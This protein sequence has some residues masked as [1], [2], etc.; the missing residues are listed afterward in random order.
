MTNNNNKSFDADAR[1]V[2]FLGDKLVDLT[3]KFEAMSNT[4]KST[5]DLEN[6]NRNIVV[7]KLAMSSREID[8]AFKMAKGVAEKFGRTTTFNASLEGARASVQK[9]SASGYNIQEERLL[10]YLENFLSKH[11]AESK[12]AIERGEEP[13]LKKVD[14]KSYKPIIEELDKKLGVKGALTGVQNKLMSFFGDMAKETD[15]KRRRMVDDLVEGLASSKFIGGALNDTFKLIG[16]LG[17]SWLSHFGQFGRIL[18]GAFYVAMS[19]FGPILAKMLVEGLGKLMWSGLKFLSGVILKGGLNLGR[20]VVSLSASKGGPLDIFSP[21]RWKMM[22]EAGK[23]SSVGRLAGSVGVAAGAGVAAAWAGREAADSWKQGRKGNAAA[24][25]T[26]AAAL[27]LGALAALIV[28]VTAPISLTLLGVGAAVTAIAFAWKKFGGDISGWFKNLFRRKDEEKERD[29]EEK[30]FWQRFWDWLRDWWPFGNEREE[31]NGKPSLGEQLKRGLGIQDSTEVAKVAN[32][33]ASVNKQG[34]VINIGSLTKAQAS[35]VAQAYRDDDRFK[36]IY[37]LVD[38]KHASLASFQNDWAI[39]DKKGNATQAVLYKGASKNLEQ[40]W[41]Q[42][43]AGGM[44]RE[45]AQLLKYTSGRA[46]KSSGHSKS[47]KWKSHDNFLNL[48][49]DMAEGNRWTDKEW[50]TALRTLQPIAAQQGFEIMYEGYDSRGKR[51]FSKDFKGGLTN[52]H[53]HIQPL[54]KM[55]TPGAK[56][57]EES[58]K[59]QKVEATKHSVEAEKALKRANK[60]IDELDKQNNTKTEGA[61]RENTIKELMKS[62][63]FVYDDKQKT[64]VK[65]TPKNDKVSFLSPTGND[66]FLAVQQNLSTV[67]MFGGNQERIG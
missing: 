4:L 1:Y 52:R 61:I 16:L 33:L 31:N 29:K 2:E 53:F 56:K 39:R 36:N 34:A 32:N 66:D 45:R 17:A 24:L 48:V 46:T 5:I 55:E 54:A 11:V 41:D 37:E 10:V 47:G 15:K 38:S 51:H 57:N 49:T 63:G 23:V 8:N 19:A 9:L 7:N 65:P 21:G 43:V 27:G 12:R 64:W 28:G 13:T 25:G 58:Y 22:S 44:T 60:S 3:E 35:D 50:E 67:V 6:K 18:G 59:K 62:Q 14:L 20:A 30:G 42:L 40:F 26:G